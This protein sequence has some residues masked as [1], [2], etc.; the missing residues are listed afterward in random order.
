MPAS[1]EFLWYGYAFSLPWLLK[2]ISV[3]QT[4]HKLYLKS[5]LILLTRIFLWDLYHTLHSTY[6]KD[7]TKKLNVKW[8]TLVGFSK[9]KSKW[10]IRN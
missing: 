4:Y 2:H 3:F 10:E 8:L 5:L 1:F 7:E 6:F 9:N